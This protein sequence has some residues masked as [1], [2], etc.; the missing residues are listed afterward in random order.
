M[1]FGP[2]KDRTL[3]SH[4]ISPCVCLRVAGGS[5]LPVAR[6]PF[7]HASAWN[8]CITERQMS[9]C[10]SLIKPSLPRPGRRVLSHDKWLQKNLAQEAWPCSCTIS[11]ETR[12]VY[13]N[14]GF[15]V[16]DASLP[17][18]GTSTRQ[19]EGAGRLKWTPE[20]S[21]RGRGVVNVCFRHGLCQRV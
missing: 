10:T 8:F 7:L 3:L 11:S 6:S 15:C 19:R 12:S 5:T 21:C 2:G 13:Q 4:T 1:C 9:T 20:T 17:A 18:Q 14:Y 16:I